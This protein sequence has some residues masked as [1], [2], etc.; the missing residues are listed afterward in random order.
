MFRKGGNTFS[1]L[2][3]SDYK[4]CFSYRVLPRRERGENKFDTLKT[5]STFHQI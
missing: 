1:A 3:N 4:P 2:L 5:N